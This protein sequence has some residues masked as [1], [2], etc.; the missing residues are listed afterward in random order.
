MMQNEKLAL[1]ISEVGWYEFKTMLEYKFNGTEKYSVHW[2][3]CSIIQVGIFT[4]EI[5]SKN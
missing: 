4:A 2:T 5:F 1:A 3:L